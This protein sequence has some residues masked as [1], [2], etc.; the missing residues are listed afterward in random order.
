M[1]KIYYLY[2]L[3]TLSLF[4]MTPTSTEAQTFEH[5]GAYMTH[6]SQQYASFNKELW[7]Y[8]KAS[9]HGRNAKVIESK[10]KTLLGTTR[11]V[12]KRIQTMPDYEGDAS[13]R[14]SASAYLSLIYHVLNDDYAKIV[15]MEEIAEQSYDLMEAYILTKEAANKKMDVASKMLSEQQEV[16]AQNHRVN[17][18]RGKNAKTDQ[19]LATAG[20]VYQYYNEIY[21]IFFKSNIQESYVMEAI[22]NNDLNALVQSQNALLKYSEE[23]LSKLDT[24]RLYKADKSMIEI[25]KKMLEFY[26]MEAKKKLPIISDFYLK[27]DSFQRIKKVIDGKK[28]GERTEEDVNTYNQA[29]SEYNAAVNEFNSTNDVLNKER[30]ILIKRWNQTSDNFIDRHV[31]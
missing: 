21:L 28:P 25:S 7:N 15:D 6:I 14:D 11:I 4:F 1:K 19:N 5:A 2:A 29:V 12:Q 27:K 8:I 16:F 20:E 24:F 23:G 18:V 3:I 26:V 22:K 30:S 10:R 13:L 9:A 31:P 17:L